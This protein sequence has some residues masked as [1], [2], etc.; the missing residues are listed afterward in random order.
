VSLW[1]K[2]SAIG[3]PI[4]GDQSDPDQTLLKRVETILEVKNTE[5]VSA[6]LD[7]HDRRACDRFI[8]RRSSSTRALFRATSIR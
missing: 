1:L 6:Q 5:E 7:Q 3:D 2:A 4:T 8:G